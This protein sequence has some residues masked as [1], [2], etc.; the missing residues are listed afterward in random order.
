[1]TALE[2]KVKELLTQYL[3]REPTETE[4]GNM[5]TDTNLVNQAIAA[6]ML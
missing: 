1:M 3:N 2:T 6:L 5:M 4:V